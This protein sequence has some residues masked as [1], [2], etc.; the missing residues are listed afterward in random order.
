MKGSYLPSITT[1]RGRRGGEGSSARNQR[2]LFLSGFGNI[3]TS[4]F[5]VP[6][7]K[8]PNLLIPTILEVSTSA[9]PIRVVVRVAAVIPGK[10]IKNGTPAVF[11]YLEGTTA[12]WSP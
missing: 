11:A 12:K 9:Q 7:S 10:D 5:K 4:K 1:L 6:T 3:D 2:D 8:R